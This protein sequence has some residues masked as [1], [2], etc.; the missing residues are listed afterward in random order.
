MYRFDLEPNDD[1]FPVDSPAKHARLPLPVP[2]VSTDVEGD[3]DD[4]D[5]ED[6][7]MKE[8]PPST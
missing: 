2:S 4:E 8:L 3:G 5:D 6:M 7:G 1:D